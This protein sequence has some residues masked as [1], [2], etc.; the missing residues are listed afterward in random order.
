M[1]R[2]CGSIIYHVATPSAGWTLLPSVGD[3]GTFG[4]QGNLASQS[5]VTGFG[6]GGGNNVFYGIPITDPTNPYRVNPAVSTLPGDV[7]FS[8]YTPTGYDYQSYPSAQAFNSAAPASDQRWYMDWHAL[9]PSL[10]GNAGGAQVINTNWNR[11]ALVAGTVGVYKF[12]TSNSSVAP[13]KVM[14]PLMTTTKHLIQDTSSASVGNV[15]TDATAYQGCY[16]YLAGECRTGSA[17]GDVYLSVPN[18]GGQFASNVGNCLVNF[19]DEDMPCVISTGVIGGALVQGAMDKPNVTNNWRKLTGGFT[20]P[21]QHWDYT[22]G[23]SDPTGQWAFFTGYWLNAIRSDMLAAKLPPFPATSTG[24]T[25]FTQLPVKVASSTNDQA[26]VTFGYAENG[27]SGSFY[28]TGR[29]EACVTSTAPTQ[30]NP[31]SYI[32]SDA[33]GWVACAAG[34][35]INVPVIPGR[36]VY[37]QIQQRNSGTSQQISSATTFFAAP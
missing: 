26:R 25:T 21:G 8:G 1:L 9:L 22:S 19:A 17:V 6:G 14:P 37:Y 23:V 29:Q 18:A 27:P 34:C 33:P 31:F 32:T 3:H 2:A 10:G 30:A 16:A 15:I 11:G 20:L 13:Y 5:Y 7:P 12:T 24:T 28:C 35:T 4:Q 36:T